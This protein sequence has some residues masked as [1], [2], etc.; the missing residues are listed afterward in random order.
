[1]NLTDNPGI[2]GGAAVANP[3]VAVIALAVTVP[4]FA[5]PGLDATSVALATLV[6]V[7]V[8]ATFAVV[9]VGILVA[10]VVDTF[11]AVVMHV[12]LIFDA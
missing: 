5:A 12:A 7:A 11:F 8:F 3:A 10:A 1:M 6:A 4:S 2:K 9:S